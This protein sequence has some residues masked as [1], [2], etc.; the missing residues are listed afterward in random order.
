[1]FATMKAATTAFL[2]FTAF[3]SAS[4]EDKGILD[5]VDNNGAQQLQLLEDT[6]NQNSG[7]LNVDG[8]RKVG[9]I[10][11]RELE[12]IGFAVRWVDMPQSM[13]RGG[14]L[15]AERDF[16]EGPNLLLIGHLDTVFEPDSPFQRFER[17]GDKLRGPGVVDMKGGNTVV[18]YAMRALIDAQAIKG[19]KVTIFFTGDEES[20]GSPLTEAREQL[21]AAGKAADYALNFEGGSPEW[22]VI[23]RRGSSKWKLEVTAKRAHSSG[24][25][26]DDSGA[27]AAFEMARILNRFYGEVRG[28]LGLTFNPGMVAAGSTIEPVGS[29]G[30]LTVSG[31][32]N[33]IA[34]TATASGGLRFMNDAQLRAAERLMRGIVEDSLP[35]TKA[36]ITFQ[37]RYPAM[38]LTE[39]NQALLDRLNIVHARLGLEPAQSFPPEKRGA[40]DISFVA[41]YV[42]SMDGLGVAGSG[43]HTVDE[44]MDLNSLRQATRR[45]A[46][47]VADLL[48]AD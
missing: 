23:G 34:E 3:T 47:L 18:I 5:A 6:V 28:P 2:L 31:K 36:T 45:T 32:D 9:E 44:E 15:V 22:G 26:S 29:A 27:G 20:V 8:V 43:S 35:Q 16:G 10:Y 14:H 13:A 37:D 42:A 41:P 33:V 48:A 46:L 4:A 30:A 39:A 25:F 40:A 7:T 1:M 24:I 19:G 12:D 17:D 38:E 21:I 11:R